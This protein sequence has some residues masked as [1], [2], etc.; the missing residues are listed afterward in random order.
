VLEAFTAFIKSEEF[1]EVTSF[2][3]ENILAERPRHKV[4]KN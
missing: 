4:Y 2:G 3:L 1:K